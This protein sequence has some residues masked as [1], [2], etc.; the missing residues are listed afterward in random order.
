MENSNAMAP[1]MFYEL[2]GYYAKIRC[3]CFQRD[4][5]LLWLTARTPGPFASRNKIKTP[6]SKQKPEPPTSSL[7]LYVC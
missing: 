5:P 4:N 7:S 6:I 2:A 3:E 1:N